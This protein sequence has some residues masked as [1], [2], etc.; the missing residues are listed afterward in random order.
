[1]IFTSEDMAFLK[2]QLEYCSG[3]SLYARLQRVRIGILE[4]ELLAQKYQPLLGNDQAINDFDGTVEGRMDC[5]DNSSNTTT[6]LHV[7]QD[8]G[9]L[10]GWEVSLPEVR[11]L[12][13][14]TAIHW[15]AVIIDQES[16]LPWSVDSWYRPNGHL[17][18]VMPLQSWI[19]DKKAWEPPFEGMN[20]NP[21]SIYELCNEAQQSGLLGTGR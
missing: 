9:Q 10:T 4:M 12:F 5:V 21:Y 6:Y 7:L 1:M 3:L 13:N 20:P 18:L 16:G 14:V 19:N 2:S 15:T 11:H 17:P 8:I